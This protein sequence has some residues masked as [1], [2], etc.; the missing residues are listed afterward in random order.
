MVV[1][2]Q[3]KMQDRWE[4][5]FKDQCKINQRLSDIHLP[6]FGMLDDFTNLNDRVE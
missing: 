6:E 3:Q 4:E 5:C 1:E 2:P